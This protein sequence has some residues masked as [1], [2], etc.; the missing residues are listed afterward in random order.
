MVPSHSCRRG[1]RDR[2]GDLPFQFLD[3]Q[4]EGG[5]THHAPLDEL[6]RVNNRPVIAVEVLSDELERRAGNLSAEMHRKLPCERDALIGA[7]LIAGP[8]N[9]AAIRR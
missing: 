8:R 2:P 6:V 4:P 5:I 3:E 9:A 7:L 1:C